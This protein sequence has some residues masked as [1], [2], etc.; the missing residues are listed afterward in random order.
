MNQNQPMNKSE[1]THTH[2]KRQK[3][4]RNINE[5]NKVFFIGDKS[6][7]GSGYFRTRT[8]FLFE[9]AVNSWH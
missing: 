3:I 1:H 8:S 6:E 2:E 7:F 9:F 5:E 4:Q